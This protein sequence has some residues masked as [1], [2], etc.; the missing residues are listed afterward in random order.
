MKNLKSK[1][2]SR[3]VLLLIFTIIVVIL[4]FVAFK[5]LLPGGAKPKTPAPENQATL[6]EE[7]EVLLSFDPNTVTASAGGKVNA[8][9]KIDAGDAAVSYVKLDVSFDPSVLSNVTVTPFKDPTS[10]LSYSFIS[11][12]DTRNASKGSIVITYTLINGA[13]EQKGRGVLAK[14]SGVYKGGKETTVS[15]FSDSAVATKNPNYKL[16]VGRVNLDIFPR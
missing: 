6:L 4:L 8:D 16:T 5:F 9:I 11:D 2:K 1:L 10:A 15:L 3:P 13:A 14:F 7:K 12:V